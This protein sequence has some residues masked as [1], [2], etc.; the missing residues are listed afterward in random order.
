MKTLPILMLLLNR[1]LLLIIKWSYFQK[2]FDLEA[3]D[4]AEKLKRF[5]CQSS[6]QA[7]KMNICI[8]KKRKANLIEEN[9]QG[10]II[11]FFFFKKSLF[12]EL[13]KNFFA[14]VTKDKIK[15]M[16]LTFQKVLY[17]CAQSLE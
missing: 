4:S 2:Y 7:F 12:K 3:I 15:I 11:F 5:F 6:L 9:H 10:V 17:I 8:C 1:R 14:L 16:V 13:M